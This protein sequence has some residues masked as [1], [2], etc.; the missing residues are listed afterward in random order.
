MRYRTEIDG[1]RAIAVWLVLLFHFLPETVPLGFLGVD[2]F[3]AIS[4]YVITGQL[5]GQ[6]DQ[7]R[8]SFRAFYARRIKRIL[9]LSFVVVSVTMIAGA[10]ILL[11]ADFVG[12]TKS[13]FASSTFWANIF[14]WRDGGYFGGS[15]KL[16]PLLHMWSLSVEEQFYVVFPLV[17]WLVLGVAKWGE[18]A[19]LSV[20][21]VL[22]GL[23]LGAYLA[24]IQIGGNNPAFFLMPTRAWQF[25]AGALAVFVVQIGRIRHNAIVAAVG[26][27]GIF[28]SVFSDW[29]WAWNEILITAAAMTY[30]VF[31]SGKA[32]ADRALSGTVMR[33]LGARS[34]SLYLWH[35]PIVA[36]LGYSFVDQIPAAAIAAGIVLCFLLSEVSYRV[37]ER[38]FRYEYPLSRSLALIIVSSAIMAAVFV[39]GNRARPDDLANRFASQ[40]QTN[41][42]CSLTDYVP[43]GASRACILSPFGDGQNF[44]IL[45]NSHAQMYAP[46]IADA[47]AKNAAGLMVVPLNGCPPTVSI[48]ISESCLRA[49]K[50]NF[51]AVRNDDRISTVIIGTTYTDP[52]YVTQAGDVLRPQQSGP[53]AESLIALVDQLEMSGKTVFMIGPIPHPGF[54]IA[55]DVARKLK[56]GQLTEA[57]AQ[58]LLT[59]PLSAFDERFKG[60]ITPLSRRLGEHLILPHEGLCDQ[61]VCRLA[62]ADG[63]YFADSN[64]LGTLGLEK[65]RG[66]FGGIVAFA[67]PGR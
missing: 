38:R 45:G 7:G 63:S 44:A 50:I 34:F 35:W 17:L 41:F 2:L 12:L 61:K 29:T 14:F 22:S 36:Y 54:D 65:V 19:I 9:P 24:F 42:R 25:G 32:A 51:D 20:F 4:G 16:K 62:D 37:I 1:L 48:N 43:F 13:A 3:F 66:A 64:H 23:S 18:K 47:V 46:V 10:A 27:I 60:A 30:L 8:F 21:F 5:L 49:A 67:Q 11:H 53:F 57:E 39:F 40:I 33:Y 59:S 55:S 58:T 56:F 26:L 31:A 6:M 52:E 15:D 28:V